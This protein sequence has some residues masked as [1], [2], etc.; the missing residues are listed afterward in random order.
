[1]DRRSAAR[2]ALVAGVLAEAGTFVSARRLHGVLA[3]EGHAIS[4]SSVYRALAA[5]DESEVER[6]PST[7]G[8]M[9]YRRRTSRTDCVLSCLRCGASVVAPAPEIDAW[10][11]RAARDNAFDLT[12]VR[13]VL[14]GLCGD[15]AAGGSREPEGDG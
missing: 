14:G 10:A 1:M 4:L 13:A 3:A 11:R 8:E 5:M 9:R 15:C 7:S 6:I 2:Q 12:R